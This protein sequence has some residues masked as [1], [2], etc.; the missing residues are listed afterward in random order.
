MNKDEHMQN[1]L[2]SLSAEQM[3]ELAHRLVAGMQEEKET[4]L[5]DATKASV[6]EDF[7]VNRNPPANAR[8][9]VKAKENTWEDTGELRDVET[10]DYQMTPRNRPKP[11]TKSVSCHVCKKSF[12]INESLV[13]GEFYRCNK[14]T[15]K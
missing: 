7:T 8:A 1:F 2:D 3:E 11:K 6:D 9:S 13:Y 14:C 4:N 12:K 10:P 15:G 5:P